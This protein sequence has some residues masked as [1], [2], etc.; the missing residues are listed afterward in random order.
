MRA[1]WYEKQGPAHDVLTVGEMPD[2]VPGAGE[3]RIRVVASGINP[4]DTKKRGDVFSLGMPY[5]R[6]IPHSDGAGTVDLV[7]TGISE[8]LA[9]KRVWCYGAQSYRPFGTA[10]EFTVVPADHVVPLPDNVSFEIGACLGIPGITGHRAVHATG[11]VNGKTVLVQGA[12]GAVGV[13]AVQLARFAGAHVIGTVRSGPEVETARRAGA[14]EVLFNDDQLITNVRRV[15]PDGLDHIVEVAF[16]ANIERDVEML[17]LG[18]SLATYATNDATHSVP[19]WSMVF[20]NIQVNFLGSDDFPIAA[21][22]AAAKEL[23]RALES[24]WSGFEI[25]ERVPLAQ[26]VRAHELV[27]HPARPGRVVIVI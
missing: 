7:G 12:G 3:V 21:K 16:A 10:A 24:G 1:A 8:E 9:G 2:P 5:P 6:V 18:G 11:P 13:C 22:I 26:I 23:S 25:G 27:D 15:A 14:H 17:K 20:K 19:F 4:G